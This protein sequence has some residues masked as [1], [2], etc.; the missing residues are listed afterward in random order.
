[1]VADISAV[2][3][4]VHRIAETQPAKQS[5]LSI[6]KNLVTTKGHHK[7]IPRRTTSSQSLKAKRPW[8]MSKGRVEG[9]IF[10]CTSLE[11]LFRLGGCSTL[12]LP[13]NFSPIETLLIPVSLAATARN[14]VENGELFAP[15]KLVGSVVIIIDRTRDTWYFQ[16]GWLCTLHTQTLRLLQQPVSI[17]CLCGRFQSSSIHYRSE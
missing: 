2:R 17:S 3:K 11:E 10:Q 7:K 8:S 16:G 1:M 4:Q 15:K 12:K 6:F 14:I 5:H 13:A 9:E